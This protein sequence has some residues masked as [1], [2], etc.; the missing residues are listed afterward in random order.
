L[1]AKT[2]TDN[3]IVPL[4]VITPPVRP[5]PAVIDVTVPPDPTKL[6]TP[7][8]DTAPPPVIPPD[9]LMVTDELAK[10]ALGIPVGKSATTRDLKV[11][12]AAAPVVGPAHT[13]FAAWVALVIVNVPEAVIVAE[14]VP[15]TNNSGVET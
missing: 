9:V 10:L 15:L 14:V 2:G 3:A 5:V 1:T 8:N 6:R 12:T 13:V 11:G 4:V 7:P